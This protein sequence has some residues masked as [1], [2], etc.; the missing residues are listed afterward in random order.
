MLNLE[1]IG[2]NGLNGVPCNP[3][4]GKPQSYRDLAYLMASSWASF[5]VDLDVNSWREG[6][7]GIAAGT[8]VWPVYGSGDG[9]RA[10]VFDANVSS[11]AELDNFREK[12]IALINRAAIAFKR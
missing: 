12:G 9:A 10:Y 5:V 4:E 3:F 8:E 11:Y 1:G 2:Y 6:K 7:S